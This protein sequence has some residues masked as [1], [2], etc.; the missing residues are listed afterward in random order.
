VISFTLSILFI[1]YINIMDTSDF[2]KP[3]PDVPILPSR[4][5]FRTTPIT[6]FTRPKGRKGRKPKGR[7]KTTQA[8]TRDFLR[9]KQ[10]DEARKGRELAIKKA[11][12]T[13]A[14]EI[15]SLALQRERLRQDQDFKQEQLQLQDYVSQRD[16]VRAERDR[17][18]RIAQ[19]E[20]ALYLQ[21]QIAQ[22]QANLR[23][24]DRA[25]QARIENLRQADRRDDLRRE[26]QRQIETDR[27]RQRQIEFQQGQAEAEREFRQV[28]R[29][30]EEDRRRQEAEFRQQQLEFQRQK[31]EDEDAFRATQV[32]RQQQNEQ[33]QQ[34]LE[35]RRQQEVRA[36]F[37]YFQQTFVEGQRRE[38]ER[39]AQFAQ[40]IAD[41][42]NRGSEVTRA[43]FR[44]LQEQV[45]RLTPRSR[46]SPQEERSL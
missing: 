5:V 15:E 22:Q 4:A 34:T 42:K 40:L 35:A 7:A 33:L 38:G 21:A 28:Q 16:F 12:D 37:Q 18:A 3:R 14:R 44:N 10:A 45:E 24:A 41:S 25:E 30:F 27:F 11:R 13:E 46:P 2:R 26:E 19:S 20:R 6:P 8:Q 29:G 39:Q 17:Q 23:I 43:D 9:I 32:A 36:M 1:Y 31:E